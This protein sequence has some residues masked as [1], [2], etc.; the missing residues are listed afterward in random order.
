MLNDSCRQRRQTIKPRVKSEANET[1]G[2]GQIWFSVAVGDEHM[3]LP[4]QGEHL[5]R[6]LPRVAAEAALTWAAKR[7]YLS[8][9]GTKTVRSH[10]WM[11]KT[12]PTELRANAAKQRAMTE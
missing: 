5:S 4:L 7:G 3:L 6:L 1:L 9:L 8:R 11:V 12:L 2:R 10:G